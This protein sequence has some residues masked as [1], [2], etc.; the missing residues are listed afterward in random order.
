MV[1]VSN[2]SILKTLVMISSQK[3]RFRSCL[4]GGEGGTQETPLHI[5]TF[6]PLGVRNFQQ[7]FQETHAAAL[8]CFRMVSSLNAIRFFPKSY[9]F[10]ANTTFVNDQQFR[11]KQLIRMKCDDRD[12]IESSVNQNYHRMTTCYYVIILI[13]IADQGHKFEETY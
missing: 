10:K 12:Q 11:H 5:K 1:M 4:P 2:L 6:T 9:T 7:K 13:K 3:H 8:V